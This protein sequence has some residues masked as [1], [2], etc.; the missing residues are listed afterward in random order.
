[1]HWWSPRKICDYGSQEGGKRRQKCLALLC[2]KV[3]WPTVWDLANELSDKSHNCAILCSSWVRQG[4]VHSLL[5]SSAHHCT[6]FSLAGINER[7]DKSCKNWNFLSIRV[8]KQKASFTF[9]NAREGR[10]QNEGNSIPKVSW[11]SLQPFNT[12]LLLKLLPNIR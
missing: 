10:V 2:V 3:I 7:L 8:E 4:L 11:Y 9:L 5:L 1:M 12:T 6:L